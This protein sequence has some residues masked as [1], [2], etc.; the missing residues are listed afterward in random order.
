MSAEAAVPRSPQQNLRHDSHRSV[1]IRAL[2]EFAQ[3]RL[4]KASPLRDVLLT[5]DDEISVHEFVGKA[6]TWLA[7]LRILKGG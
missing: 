7:L 4:P 3:E 6:K 5:E 2:K 1:S